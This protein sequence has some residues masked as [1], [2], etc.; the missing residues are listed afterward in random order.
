MSKLDF[1]LIKYYYDN[2]YWSEKMVRDAVIKNKITEEQ[3]TE[4]TGFEY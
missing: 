2:K 4:I 1:D 3:Y